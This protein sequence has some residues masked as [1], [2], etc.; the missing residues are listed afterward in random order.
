MDINW[1]LVASV[2]AVAAVVGI[3]WVAFKALEEFEQLF[4]YKGR[5]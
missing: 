5:F 4:N 1:V 2:T 3:G